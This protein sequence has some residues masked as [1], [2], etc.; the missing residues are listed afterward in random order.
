MAAIGRLQVWWDAEVARLTPRRRT[1]LD[2]MLTH[3]EAIVVPASLLILGVFGV[4]YGE[5]DGNRFRLAASQMVGPG[6]LHVFGDKWLQIG[7]LYLFPLGVADRLLEPWAGSTV[8]G[9][10]L[11]AVQGALVVWLGMGTTKRAAVLNGV[12]DLLPRWVVGAALASGGVLSLAL[13]WGHPEEVALALLIVESGMLVARGRSAAGGAVLGLAFGLKAWAPIGAGVFLLPRRVRP[14]VVAAATAAL[15][16][17]LVYLPFVTF[18]EMNTFQYVW[19]FRD[20][21]LLGWIADRTGASEWLLRVAQGVVAALVG[22]AVARARWSSPALVALVVVSA[23][24]VLEPYPLPYYV[25]PA[26][27]AALVW[28]WT[29]PARSARRWRWVVTVA[30]PLPI[31]LRAV[32]DPGVLVHTWL[33]MVAAVAVFAVVADFRESRRSSPA[34]VLAEERV[35]VVVT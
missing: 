35:D 26:V 22:A 18:G 3:P 14:F 32:L 15:V 33:A 9:M 17:A 1:V 6:F 27:A 31:Q 20:G 2:W 34:P 30:S 21:T 12:P 5:G 19:H 11:V 25:C 8:T 28:A 13:E 24:L 7:P 4:E 23:R 16:G 10:I 29:S